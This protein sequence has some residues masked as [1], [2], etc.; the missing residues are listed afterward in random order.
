[1]EDL[2]A[3]VSRRTRSVLLLLLPDLVLG[4]ELPAPVEVIDFLKGLGWD[5]GLEQFKFLTVAAHQRQE[6]GHLFGR[7][8][9]KGV[10]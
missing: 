10:V 2:I 5:V 7:P 3:D 9:F 8:D 1:M 4:G 6:Q